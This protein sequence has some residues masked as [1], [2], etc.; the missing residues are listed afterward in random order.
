MVI[1]NYI[2]EEL[3]ERMNHAEERYG[4]LASSHEDE[5]DL[6]HLYDL[7]VLFEENQTKIY[8]DKNGKPFAKIDKSTV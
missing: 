2:Q 4:P 8:F 1:E 5:I 6:R 7:Q 3:E